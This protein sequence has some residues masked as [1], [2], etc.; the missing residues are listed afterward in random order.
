MNMK[1][2]EKEFNPT[3][4]QL[5]RSLSANISGTHK[6]RNFAYKAS[7]V[8]E[9]VLGG[10]IVLASM[11]SIYLTANKIIAYKYNQKEMNTP[12]KNQQQEDLINNS[13]GNDLVYDESGNIILNTKPTQEEIQKI[14]PQLYSTLL[15]D[16]KRYPDY[17]YTIDNINYIYTTPLNE[18]GT[19]KLIN[20]LVSSKKVTGETVY[21][22]MS[23][24]CESNFELQDSD[25]DIN[26]FGQFLEY[27]KN[28][29]TPFI[30]QKMDS[31]LTSL[32]EMSSPNTIF[33]NSPISYQDNSGE[34]YIIIQEIKKIF[35]NYSNTIYSI[36]ESDLQFSGQDI[37]TSLKY[38]FLT[39]ENQELFTTSTTN[40]S[41]DLDTVS[42]II[43]SAE[44]NYQ[45][46]QQVQ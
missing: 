36:R 41:Q 37:Y 46:N 10:I 44:T 4:K 24:Y 22:N 29:S 42:K 33:F 8:T 45:D 13:N 2:R 28:E 27:I 9:K 25:K 16:M 26:K 40:N 19:E 20:F 34:S 21:Y 30:C 6:V 31:N 1:K 7:K 5:R 15:K 35:D 3:Q 14:I 23:Y 43:Q 12:V 32:V 11:A 39:G 17:P 18:D 38:M